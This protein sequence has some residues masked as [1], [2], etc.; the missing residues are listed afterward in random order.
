MM[1][2]IHIEDE[3]KNIDL[4][5]TLVEVH[6]KEWVQL[7]GYATN[8]VDAVELIHEK[9]PELVYLDIELKNGNAFELLQM[10]P[11]F[12]FQIIFITAHNE[13]AVKAFRLHAIDYLLKPISITELIE[14]TQKAYEKVENKS[15]SENVS[16]LLQSLQINTGM[17]YAKVGLPV[18]DG[19]VF[20]NTDEIIRCEAKGSYTVVYL[21][22]G[23]TTVIVKSLKEVQ[24]LLPITHFIRVHNSWLV[25]SRFL[26]KYYRGK[27]SYMEMEDG[28]TVPISTRKKGDFLHQFGERP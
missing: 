5:K 13:Y 25:N 10:I 6:C 24:D 14:A 20:M 19:I 28:S 12:Q 27:N 9:K 1:R 15:A 3:P 21:N 26:K 17:A 4:L 11:D 16:K 8:L 23:K 7:E 22:N 2:A 18:K